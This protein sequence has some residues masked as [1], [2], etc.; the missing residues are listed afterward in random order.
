MCKGEG[1]KHVEDLLKMPLF[2]MGFLEFFRKMQEEGI[3]AAKNYWSLSHGMDFLIPQ[4][5]EIF[6]RLVDF[7]I[8]LGFVPR[9][10]HEKMLEENE[11]LK[12][13]NTCL[14]NTIRELQ[15][16]A[17][18]AREEDMQ[19]TLQEIGAKQMGLNSEAETSL[20][21]DPISS[22]AYVK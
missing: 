19:K 20:P 3:V 12:E 13:E 8:I 18:A 16:N 4:A 2:K 5:P 22:G 15:D 21:R 1:I 14:K 7:Y 10:R 17:L 9:K 11:D 6:E